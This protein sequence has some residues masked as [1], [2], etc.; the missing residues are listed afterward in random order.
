MLKF[1]KIELL[2]KTDKIHRS[3]RTQMLWPQNFKKYDLLCWE[4][5]DF[6]FWGWLFAVGESWD[7]EEEGEI[8]EERV[9]RVGIY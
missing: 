1:K 9:G 7:G 4:D 3:I 8:G 6:F 5:R 2:T